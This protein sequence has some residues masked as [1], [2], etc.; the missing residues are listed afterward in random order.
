MFKQSKTERGA[1]P[2]IYTITFNPA[3]DYIVSVDNFRLGLTNRTSSEKL[4]AGGKGVNVSTVLKNLGM[5]NIALG[6]TAGFTGEQIRKM[7]EKDGIRTDFIELKKGSSRINVK[8][9]SIEGTEIN[10]KGPDIDEESLKELCK[11]IDML[12]D[13]D[14]LVL[15]GSIPNSLPNSIYKDFMLR[16]SDKNVRIVVDAERELVVNVLENKPFLIKPNNHE[17]ADIFNVELGTEEA[18]I[19]YAGKLKEMGAVNVLVSMAG[20]GAI[21]VDEFGEV[22]SAK[23]PKGKLVN[24]VGAGD[25]MVAG[26]LY[27]YLKYGSYD[28]A[29]KYGMAAGSASAYSENLATG[30]EIEDLRSRL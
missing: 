14:V 30:A 24:G 16:L 27:G 6:F 7:L 19:K 15:A 18:I 1:E 17:L 23:P 11:K 4:L 12:S 26:F 9:R 20:A 10:G 2:M 22:H 3:L 28:E 8:L 5:E 29:F 25:S 13:G 21:L